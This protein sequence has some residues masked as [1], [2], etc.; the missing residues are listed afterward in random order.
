MNLV[1]TGYDIHLTI[2]TKEKSM[3]SF[4]LEG[5]SGIHSY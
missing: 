4:Y 3:S 5:N 2:N 1:T